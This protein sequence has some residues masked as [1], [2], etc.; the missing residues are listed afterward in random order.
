[1]KLTKAEIDA[2]ETAIEYGLQELYNNQ[3]DY[4]INFNTL[5]SA[6]GRALAKIE[7]SGM[8]RIVSMIQT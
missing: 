8:G 3:E 4:D 5:N 1:M 2:L 7:K 6:V